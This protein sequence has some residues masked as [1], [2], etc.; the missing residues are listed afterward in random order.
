MTKHNEVLREQLR[1]AHGLLEAVIADLT[2]EQAHWTPGHKANP[3]GA[4][5]A[6]VVIGEDALVS[7]LLKE[8]VPLF[9]SNWGG[10]T[11]LS[12]MMPM[13]G[14]DG[15]GFPD[16]HNWAVSVKVDLGALGE[17]AQAVYAVTDQYL[18]EADDAEI[19]RELDLSGLGIPNRTV[20]QLF[21][22]GILSN[23]LLHTGEIACLKGLQGLKGYPF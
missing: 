19:N 9:A 18:A 8:G 21:N 23:V 7:G 12:E 2:P 13:P 5:Y 11:G 17:Y 20:G 4:N 14:S 22:G 1:D 6:H 3:I 10:K 15:P 16:W